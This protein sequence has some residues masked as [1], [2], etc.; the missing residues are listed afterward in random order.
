VENPFEFQVQDGK[1]QIKMQSY[2]YP[3]LPGMPELAIAIIFHGLNG[4]SNTMSHIAKSFAEAGIASY[5]YDYRGF[6]KSQGLPA[7]LPSLEQHF[8]DAEDFVRLVEKL[9]KNKDKPIF[10]FGHSMGGMTGFQLCLR[11]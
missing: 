5:A 4:Y 8:E 1:S 2:Y 7:Y 3:C 6:G 10:L 11:Q 9:P